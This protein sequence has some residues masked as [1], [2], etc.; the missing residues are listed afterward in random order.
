[1]KVTDT[2]YRYDYG[3]FNITTNI[4]GRQL[5]EDTRLEGTYYSTDDPPSAIEDLGE[6]AL[7]YQWNQWEGNFVMRHLSA[8]MMGLPHQYASGGEGYNEDIQNAI[9]YGERS[10]NEMANETAEGLLR[11]HAATTHAMLQAIADGTQTVR[12]AL[13]RHR[14]SRDG[15]RRR[16]RRQSPSAAAVRRRLA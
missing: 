11:D 5:L 4:T 7:D 16:T 10:D 6:V 2:T 1:V 8:A 15:R 3:D 14:S 12:R 9:V 13:G